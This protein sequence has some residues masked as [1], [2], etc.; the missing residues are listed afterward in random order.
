MP[1]DLLGLRSFV[2]AAVGPIEHL[3]RSAGGASR[4]T[5]FIEAAKRACVLRVDPGDG[6]V[7]NTALLLEMA[8]GRPELG[9]L[10]DDQRTG[11]LDSYVETGRQQHAA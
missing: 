7:A 2:E 10:S 3:S 6:P 5:W 4:I 8:S 11:V 1:E 9:H